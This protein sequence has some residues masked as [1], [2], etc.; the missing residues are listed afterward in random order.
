[1]SIKRVF[2]FFCIFLATISSL[3][4]LS[5]SVDI[6][7]GSFDITKEPDVTKRRDDD[8]SAVIIKTNVEEA[9]IY[10][11][12]K[13]VGK[14][15]FASVELSSKYYKL[16]IR[17]AGYD[18]IL[19]RIHPRKYYTY[20]YNFTMVKTCGYIN[21]K[22]YP[23]GS[24]VYIDGM[25]VSSL[26]YETDPGSHTLKVRKFGYDD[27]SKEVYVTNHKTTNVEVSLKVSPFSISR[28]NVSKNEI[29]PD[30][31]SAIGKTDISFYVTNN[32]SAIVTVSDRY[33]NVVWAHKYSSFSTWEQKLTWNGS[34]EDGDS[35]PDG[36]YTVRL[37]GPDYEASSKVKINRSLSYPLCVFTPMGSGIG[38]MPFAFANQVDYIRLFADFGPIVAVN[39]NKTSLEAF[40]LAGGLVFDFGKH[41]ELSASA[42]GNICPDASKNESSFK[43][44][45]SF[46]G[47]ACAKLSGNFSLNFAAYAGYNYDMF[48]LSG[49]ALGLSLGIETPAL[50]LGAS[51]E[52]IPRTVSFD[53]NNS[54]RRD[55]FKYGLAASITPSKTI[56]FSGWGAINGKD[57]WE[58]GLELVSMPA[59]SSFSFDVKTWMTSDFSPKIENVVINAR[60][61]LSYLF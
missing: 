27:Y 35:L 46:K 57:T 9:D 15:P 33:G 17:K 56:R 50:Y 28:F 34:G 47:T 4:A 22:G 41:F 10:I 31:S 30:Y 13:L 39:Q 6:N 45:M 11:N 54:N 60:I 61:G 38:T 29:N 49:L 18:T 20:T 25:S 23:D 55:A 59:A 48:N 19:C 3:S 43:A 37:S 1:M 21:V 12:D 58:A 42:G 44:S 32:G 5:V 40:P 26:P 2:L 24:S 16:E 53:N 51:G 7:L 14:S 52:Y 36:L 8:Y